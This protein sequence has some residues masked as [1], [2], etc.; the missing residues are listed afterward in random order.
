MAEPASKIEANKVVKLRRD[1]RALSSKRFD[2]LVVG[3]GISGASIAWDASRRGLSTALIDKADFGAE[4]S[5]GCFKIVHGGLRYLQ[6]FDIGRLRESVKEQRTLRKIAPDLVH[7]LPFLIPTYGRGM[8]SKF[9]LRAG[10]AVYD[11]LSIDR[12]F[13]IDSKHCLPSFKTISREECLKIAPGLCS[14][15]LSGGVIYYDCQMTNCERLTFRVVLSAARDGAEVCNYLAAVGFEFETDSEGGKRISRT[16]VC[17]KQSGRDYSIEADRVIIA[18]GPWNHCL[19]ALLGLSGQAAAKQNDSVFSAGVQ[20]VVPQIM[21]KYAIAI[22]S[23]YRDRAAHVARGG[24]SFFMQPWRGHTLIGTADRIYRGE[25]DEFAI[26]LGSDVSR[27]IGDLR[28]VY[29]SELLTEE[30]VRHVFGGLRLVDT[31]LLSHDESQC[32]HENADSV[33]ARNPKVTDF[34]EFSGKDKIENLMSVSCV[35]YTTFRS[36]AEQVVDKL[37]SVS[38]RPLSDC[39]TS[40]TM[41]ARATADDC[42]SGLSIEEQTRL[43][44]REEMA[45]RLSDVILRRL[46]VGTLGC[47]ARGVLESAANAMAEELGWSSADKDEEIRA[48]EDFYQHKHG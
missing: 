9:V 41:L 23:R 10:L 18:A 13:G 26:D 43:A 11:L 15:G 46:E 22:E 38:L 24:R 32:G 1:P 5:S 17:D 3:G 34:K 33:V 36:L 30:N 14:D 2:L 8:K 25:P 31:E 39:S 40:L 4:T 7:P 29:N 48:M 27:L 21:E 44:V 35:K 6:H 19:H 42:L 37:S 20:I 28:S 16:L 47:P 45:V 12:N